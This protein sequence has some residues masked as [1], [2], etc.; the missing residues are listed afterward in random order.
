[1]P[2]GAQTATVTFNLN[3]EDITVPEGFSIWEAAHGRGLVIPHLCHKPEPG[4]RS[5]GNCRACMVEVEGERTSARGRPA[6]SR[7]TWSTWD[8][9]RPWVATHRRILTR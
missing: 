7:K 5:D 3:G 4:Y 2:D 6:S 1:M 8:V 9:R